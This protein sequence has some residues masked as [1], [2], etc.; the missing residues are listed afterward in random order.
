MDAK[1][2]LSVDFVAKVFRILGV[3]VGKD[4]QTKKGCFA[5]AKKS[6]PTSVPIF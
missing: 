6:T 4:E 5:K 1:L 3:D 2:I